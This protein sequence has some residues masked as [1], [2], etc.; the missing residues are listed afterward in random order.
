[1]AQPGSPRFSSSYPPGGS[2]SRRRFLHALTAAGLIAPGVAQ[3]ATEKTTLEILV[4]NGGWGTASTTD[5]RTVLRT[6]AQEIWRWCPGQLIRPIRVYHR[7]DFPQTDFLHDWRGRIRVGLASEDTRWAQMAFQ[8]GHEFCHV[9]AQHSA[10]A[11]RS[12]HPPRHANLWFEECLC[13]T[14]SLFVLRRLAAAWR[15]EPP[16]PQWHSYADALAAYATERLARADH[17]LPAG[18]SFSAWF[19]ENASELVENH[20][21]RAKNVIIARQMLPLFEAEPEGWEALCYLNLGQREQGKPRA[22]HF[23]EWQNAAPAELRPFIARLVALFP[24]T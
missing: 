23:A 22:Q 3:A 6:S 9:L 16:Y 1:M 19:R 13:E 24:Q 17:Q 4:D 11:K 5:I 15:S 20:A 7:D 21:L 12:W 8:F 2:V 14:G 10:A 18:V